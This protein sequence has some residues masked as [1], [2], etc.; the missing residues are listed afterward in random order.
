MDVGFI[1]LR[2]V[3]NKEANHYWRLCYQSLRRHYPGNR[4]LIIDDNSDYSAL[5][6]EYEK[7]LTNTKIIRSEFPGRGEI[8]PYYYF[9]RCK[10]FDTAVIIHDSTF[11]NTKLDFHVERHRPIWDFKNHEWDQPADEIRLLKCLDNSQEL[12]DLHANL[13]S[14]RG[15]FGGLAIIKHSYLEEVELRY[16]LTKL[17]DH[18]KDRSQRKSFERVIG[19]VLGIKDPS[20]PLL[21]DIHEYFPKD[22]PFHVPTPSWVWPRLSDHP[23]IKVF[24]GR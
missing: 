11:I 5:D 9:L 20:L 4:V 10:P 19:C 17:L 23:I 15:Y 2:H 14:W 24:V 8:L 1:I 22:W 16:G 12:L 18:I 21:G 13:S 6:L 7:I 3:T